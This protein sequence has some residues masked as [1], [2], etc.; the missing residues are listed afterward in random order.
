MK[1]TKAKT[2]IAIILLAITAASSSIIF[3]HLLGRARIADLTE[4]N[5]YSLS[6]GTQNIIK[7]ISQPITLKLYYSRQSA[8]EGP[9]GIRFWNNYFLYVRDLLQEYADK[10]NGTIRLE[11]IDP[12][13]YSIQEEEAIGYGLKRYDLNEDSFIF[14]LAAVTDLGKHSAIDF[15][16]PRRQILV[17]YD[18]S[19]L[20]SDLTQRQKLTIGVL[21]SLPVL[22]DNLPP[23]MMMMLQQ[24]GKKVKRPW[25]IISELRQSYDVSEAKIHEGQFVN[26]PDFLL[27]IHPKKFEKEKLFAIDQYVM[28]GGKLIVITDPYCVMDQP[29]NQNPMMMQQPKENARASELNALLERWGVKTDTTQTVADPE[30]AQK[31][32]LSPNQ[33]PQPFAPFL[34]LSGDAISKSSPMVAGLHN[35][36]MILAGQINSTLAANVEVLPLITSSKEANLWQPGPFGLMRPPTMMQMIRGFKKENTG[37]KNLAVMLKGKFLSNFKDGVELEIK[38]QP[39]QPNQPAAQTQQPSKTIKLKSINE[40]DTENA[41]IVISDVDMFSDQF[42]YQNNGMFGMSKVGDNSS[43]LLNAIEV[44]GGESDLLDIRTRGIYLRPFKVVD[45]IEKQSEQETAGKVEE[46]NKTIAKFQQQLQQIV[47]GSGSKNTE[48]LKKDIIAKK[49]QLEAEILRANRQLRQLQQKKRDKVRAL[50][51]R[52][53]RINLAAAPAIVL[54][55]AIIVWIRRKKHQA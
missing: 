50:Q 35:I 25:A 36:S 21:S 3:N 55:I 8:L 1:S 9:E 18:V 42:A 54:I 52:L 33:P 37:I 13:T 43:L 14:G 6:A 10:S 53:E 16:E 34:S 2:I 38:A 45:Q 29:K 22:G 26:D 47:S 7:K 48:L 51:T 30:F 28:R 41:I 49:R 24:Q 5:L 11:V 31:V 44:L 32:P 40:S 15:F 23:Y 27:V 20:L 39:P 12:K 17:E 46:I 4:D 19:K